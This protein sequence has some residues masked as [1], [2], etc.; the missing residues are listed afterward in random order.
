MTDTTSHHWQFWVDRGG[1]FTDIV[2]RR[3][4]GELL[5]RKLL[6]ENPRHYQDAAVEGIRRIRAEFPQFAQDGSG[7]IESV[8]M[9][10]TVATNALLERKGEDT[11]L[12]ISHGLRDQLEIGYQTRPDIFAINIAQ[13]DLLYKSVYEAPERVLAD[14]TVD[15]P[16]DPE[17][18]QVILR[19]ARESGFTSLAVVFMHAYKYPQ[20]ELMVGEIAQ[21]MGFTQISL[22]HKVS[23][24]IKLVPRGDTTVADAYLSPVL[25]LQGLY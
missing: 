16:L 21:E 23:P 14:G 15:I 5:S 11:C 2:A 18:I 4:D 25:N 1:T 12:L 20:H 9:G 24:L 8:K 13:P 22:S 19:E 7:Q 6:S 10:T 3:P 17:G